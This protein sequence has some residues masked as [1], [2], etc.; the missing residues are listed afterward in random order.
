M[1]IHGVLLPRLLLASGYPCSFAF[2]T[3][4]WRLGWWGLVVKTK[5]WQWQREHGG[6]DVTSSTT[7]GRERDGARK[8]NRRCEEGRVR[9]AVFVS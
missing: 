8:E 5:R 3:D 7:M 6:D 1:K 4:P 9:A 2:S